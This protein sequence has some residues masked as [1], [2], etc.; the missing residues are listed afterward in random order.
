M[1]NDVF[2]SKENQ[3]AQNNKPLE[4]IAKEGGS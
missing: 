2:V 3:V 4:K 1:K